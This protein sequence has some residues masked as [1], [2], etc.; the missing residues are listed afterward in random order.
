MYTGITGMR[1]VHENANNHGSK[2]DF[3]ILWRKN[4]GYNRKGSIAISFSSTLNT[5]ETFGACPHVA[6]A[7]LSYFKSLIVN[8]AA[9]CYFCRHA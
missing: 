5:H 9:G 1:I 8:T 7:H 4:C 6:V 2:T 3:L